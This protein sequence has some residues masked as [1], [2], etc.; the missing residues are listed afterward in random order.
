MPRTLI[1]ALF[2]LAT[3]GGCTLLTN[4]LL[5]EPSE[6][7]KPEVVE[8]TTLQQWLRMHQHVTDMSPERAQAALARRSP[9]TKPRQMY[10]Y[11]LLSQQTQLY[12]GWT[13]ARDTFRALREIE[14]LSTEQKQLAGIL[15]EYNQTRINWHQRHSKLQRDYGEQ[16]KQLVV[17]ENETAELEQKIQALTD[18]EEAISTRKEQ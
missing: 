3:L 11:A 17:S 6:P 12:D 10:Y 15:E 1:L 7:A 13:K 8:Y 9:P 2:L 16:Q 14:S 5:V 4:D 18:L